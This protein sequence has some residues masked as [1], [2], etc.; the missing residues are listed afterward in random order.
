VTPETLSRLAESGIQLVSETKGY[1]IFTRGDCVAMAKL[2]GDGPPGLGSTGIMTDRGL[3]YPIERG[4]Q[5]FLSGKGGDNPASDEQL[6]TL[7]KF[8]QDLKA[9]LGLLSV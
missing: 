6:E 5:V 9:G 2:S 3:A 8:S 4:G 1:A 7:R